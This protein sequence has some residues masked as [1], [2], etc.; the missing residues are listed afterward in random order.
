M[1]KRIKGL[2][3]TDRMHFD[4]VEAARDRAPMAL[5][6]ADLAF[7][8]SHNLGPDSPWTETWSRL[9]DRADR[10]AELSESEA[11]EITAAIRRAIEE[12]K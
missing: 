3:L 1:T 11:K 5:G 10:G 8:L 12:G 9:Q 6:A 2:D 4:A 7:K